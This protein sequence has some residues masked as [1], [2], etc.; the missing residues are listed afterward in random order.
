MNLNDLKKNSLEEL[1][2]KA[3]SL[4][5]A[6]RGDLEKSELLL[7]I[8]RSHTQSGGSV[9]SSGTLEILG[10]GFGFLRSTKSDYSPSPEDIYVSPSQIRRFHLNTG[11]D[12]SGVVRPPKESER[13]FA[14]L[15]VETIN[16][17]STDKAK[18]SQGFTERKAIAS[19]ERLVIEPSNETSRL[20]AELCP[21]G[22]GQ[23]ALLLAPPRSHAGNFL[24]ELAKS[25][26]K[27]SKDLT[28]ISLLISERPEFVTEYQNSDV[29][30]VVAS[31]FEEPVQK[32]SQ[33]TDMVLENAKRVADGGKDVL[34][35]VNSLTRL[36][37]AASLGAPAAATNLPSGLSVKGLQNTKKLFAAGR[38]LEGA[39]SVTVI[40]IL[41]DSG[42][43][44]DRFLR[45]E[46][47]DAANVEMQFSAEAAALGCLVPL[48][49]NGYYNS[50]ENQ[51]LD[52]KEQK[53]L[54][55]LRKS[56]NTP[57][58]WAALQALSK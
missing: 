6:T 9:T 35:L 36:A 11:D 55:A 41:R 10:D 19:T 38:N 56:L 42:S 39:G 31:S 30:E 50:Q 53:H 5:I 26:H 51:L 48:S 3:A 58:D 16:G 33:I 34:V 2:S 22:K 1:S 40:A 49:P 15:R 45:Q 32:H 47:S 14:L 7:T 24:L 28:L 23:R 20:F 4:G 44:N 37:S 46:L 27:A 21:I 12:V 25:A 18:T 17:L 29:G 57:G 54:A 13:Y 8:L 43:E 52:S